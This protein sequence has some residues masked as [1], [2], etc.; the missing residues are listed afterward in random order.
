MLLKLFTMQWQVVTRMQSQ[1][2]SRPFFARCKGHQGKNCFE[3][4]R[5]HVGVVSAFIAHGPSDEGSNYNALRWA[6]RQGHRNLVAQILANWPDLISRK[7]SHVL[8]EAAQN[9]Q[10]E[11][12]TQLLAMSPV[13]LLLDPNAIHD[14]ARGGYDEVL[15]VMLSCNPQSSASPLSENVRTALLAAATG[16]HESTVAMLLS[17][18]PKLIHVVAALHCTKKVSIAKQLLDHKP[19][20]IDVVGPQGWTALHSAALHGSIEII[21]FLLERRP[22]LSDV[23]DVDHQ[24]A[25]HLAARHLHEEVFF[26]LLAQNP[27]S[28]DVATLEHKNILHCAVQAGEPQILDA[29][30][31]LRPEFACGVDEF[32]NTALHWL[33]QGWGRHH[34]LDESH[35][36]KLWQLNPSALQ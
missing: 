7:P 18:E 9:N 32:G 31:E 24:N 11:I 15:N 30:L 5:G 35:W 2:G 10:V 29:I 6:A 23:V 16:G 26:K 36:E 19:E 33:F 4:R 12:V 28:I 25:L 21:D 8:S 22:G 14:A 3:V 13:L 34:Q 17:K 1:A 20:L 27:R